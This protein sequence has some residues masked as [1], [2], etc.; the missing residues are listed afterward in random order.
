VCSIN[1]LPLQYHIIVSHALVRSTAHT[2]LHKWFHRRFITE[3]GEEEE[4]REKVPEILPLFFFLLSVGLIRLFYVCVCAMCLCVFVYH[5]RIA[6]TSPA[7][8][9][10]GRENEAKRSEASDS[11]HTVISTSNT[12]HRRIIAATTPLN[13]P[14]ASRPAPM[15]RSSSSARPSS[16][17][18]PAHAPTQGG[19]PMQ[20]QPQP[21]QPGLLGQMAA[22][23]GGVAIVSGTI[24]L[25]RCRIRWPLYAWNPVQEKRPLDPFLKESR[26]Q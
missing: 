25:A 9:R 7:D 6:P 8:K 15:A 19:V 12:T 3:E 20:Q 5:M 14:A 18:V 21:R 26:K 17:G 13:S 2:C 4:E 11:R 1:L 24:K 10:Q 16:S 22:T 23:A